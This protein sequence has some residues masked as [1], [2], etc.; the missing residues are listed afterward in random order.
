MRMLVTLEF[1]DP[2]SNS[3][4]HRVLMMGRSTD[5]LQAGDVGLSLDEVK[6]LMSAIQDQLVSAQ[7][8]EI[9]DARRQC[10]CGKKL[11]IKDWKLRRIH[12]A[13][14]RLHLPSPR[15]ISCACGGSRQRAI[16]PLKAGSRDGKLETTVNQE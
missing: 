1:A 9:V 10:R 12:T 16:P 2:G 14:G 5:N 6:T 15:L 8:A 13:W 4:T 11:N 3:G 7:A